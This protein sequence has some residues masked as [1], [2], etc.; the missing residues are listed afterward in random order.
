MVEDMD[1][2]YNGI[3]WS[4]DLGSEKYSL[5]A[6]QGQISHLRDQASALPADGD[7]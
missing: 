4:E 3:P 7:E 2:I 6:A 5:E 1:D